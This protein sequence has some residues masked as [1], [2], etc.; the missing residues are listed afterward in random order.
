MN[1]SVVMASRNPN[2]DMM[3]EAI[4]S[5]LSQ[6]YQ[7]FELII[8]D[9][10]SD[11]PIEPK[12]SSM[13]NDSRIRVFRIQHSG[14]GA[15]LNYGIKQSNAKY[16]ARLDDDDLMCKDRLQKQYDYLEIHPEI[17]CLGTQHYD[18]VGNRFR[19]HKHY[20]ENHDEMIEA[21]LTSARL[22]MAHTALM[23]RRDAFDEVGGYRISGGGQD[24]DLILQMSRVGKLANLGE[25]LTYYTMSA[26]GLGTVNPNKRK[27]YLFAYEEILRQNVYPQHRESIENTI[28]NLKQQIAAGQKTVVRNVIIRKLLALR[29]II[30]G[31]TYK[32]PF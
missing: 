16:I 9:D 17:S 8:V 20:P 26:S 21:M 23:F 29:I 6:T 1:I 19:R 7:D 28:C 13:S 24:A 2:M 10:G 32:R 31:K 27:A 12:I 22:P 15:A 4:N 30:C 3:A 14:L 18:K 11:K 25:Y 5:I